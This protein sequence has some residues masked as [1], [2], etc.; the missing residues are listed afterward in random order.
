[1]TGLF[2][3]IFAKPPTNYL[4]KYWSNTRMIKLS[5]KETQFLAGDLNLRFNTQQEFQETMDRMMS[6]GLIEII[7]IGGIPHYQF[8]AIGFKLADQMKQPFVKN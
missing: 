4:N 7:N 2:L 5:E 8:T 1:M 6:A 3:D